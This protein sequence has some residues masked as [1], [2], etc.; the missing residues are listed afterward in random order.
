MG[1]HIFSIGGFGGIYSVSCL[2]RST[3]GTQCIGMWSDKEA[4]IYNCAISVLIQQNFCIIDEQT[5]YTVIDDLHDRITVHRPRAH[6]LRIQATVPRHTTEVLCVA[7]AFVSGVFKLY[8]I[9]DIT[10][11]AWQCVSMCVHL[12]AGV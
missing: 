1:F 10:V 11:M 7:L 6:L 2:L 12:Q 5:G 8:K 9:L 3:E 4:N